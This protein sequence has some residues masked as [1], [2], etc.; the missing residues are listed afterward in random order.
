MFSLKSH[1]LLRMISVLVFVLLSLAT[2][3]AQEDPDPNSPTPIL[4]S[5][6][7][8][9]RALTA[10]I[11][12]SKTSTRSSARIFWPNQKVELFV[13]NID[14]MDGE[15]ENAF[16]VYI[17][18]SKGREYRFPVLEIRPSGLQKGVFVVVVELRDDL[19]YW[20]EAPT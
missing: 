1:V 5:E 3:P 18:D 15:A 11:G 2:V 17:Q 19:H 20:A 7:D 14:L 12:K 10:S 13:T 16:R 9:T 6:N 4:L 8:S